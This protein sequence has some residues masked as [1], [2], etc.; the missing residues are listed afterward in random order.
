MGASRSLQNIGPEECES[1]EAAGRTRATHSSGAPRDGGSLGVVSGLAATGAAGR[2]RALFAIIHD[3][4]SEEE[5]QQVCRL[6]CIS[7][8]ANDDR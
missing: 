4:L 8:V 7:G 1:D 5:R 3:R 2:L 6:P